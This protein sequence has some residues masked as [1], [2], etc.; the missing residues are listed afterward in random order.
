MIASVC[1][2]WLPLFAGLALAPV[3]SAQL[4]NTTDKTGSTVAAPTTVI[5]REGCVTA[6]CHPGIKQFQQLHGPVRVNGCDACHELTDATKHTFK[7]ARERQGLC[8]L[9]HAQEEEPGAI[10]HEPFAQG[11]CLNCHNPH[12]S[13]MPQL[14]RGQRYS[15]N[16]LTC[17]NDMAGG[18]D[19]VHG[20]VAIGACGA[21][22]QPHSSTIRKLLNADGRELCLKCHVRT[23][24]EID[25]GSVVHSPAQG[26]CRICHDP[27]ATDHASLLLD[28]AAALC[29]QCHQDVAHA[30]TTASTQHAAVTTKRGCTNC[31]APHAGEH[32]SLLKSDPKELCFECHNQPITQPDGTTI[33]NMKQVMEGGKSLHASVTQRGCVE[34]HAIHGGDHRKLL[35]SE[36]PSTM[37]YPF[38]ENSY[39]LCFNCHDRQLVM[40][41]DTKGATGFRNGQT[42]LH[43]IHVNKDK[44]GRSCRICHDAHAASPDKSIRDNVPY[45]PGGWKLPLKFESLPTGGKCGGACHAPFEYNRDTPVKYPPRPSGNSWNGEDLVP[46]VRA[47]QTPNQTPATT[48]DPSPK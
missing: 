11:E 22:H 47:P 48:P 40:E 42:N 1:T 41:A 29:T 33:V 44:K 3:A 26:D 20:P 17:H 13:S 25:T 37:Y 38:S 31:H 9:C 36:Y 23:G 19:S 43:Y 24:I 28:D 27:H 39:A 15:D 8:T 35:V 46:G 34:C 7:S 4:L 21:C 14:L 18:H 16:C 12:G 30:M 6:E 2:R 32:T 10:L 45:G 5:P